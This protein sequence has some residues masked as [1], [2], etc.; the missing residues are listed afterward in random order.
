MNNTSLSILF[1]TAT[2]VGASAAPSMLKCSFERAEESGWLPYSMTV[3]Y[4]SQQNTID[5]LNPTEKAFETYGEIRRK[6]VVKDSAM[7]VILTWDLSATRDRK[8][9]RVEMAYRLIMKPETGAASI[10][11]DPIDYDNDF[12]AKGT[13][14]RS[15]V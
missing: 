15:K 6:R 2:S 13:C 9:Q 3:R 8:G 14:K 10:V 7:R 12:R 11:A 5:F 1:F 4:D